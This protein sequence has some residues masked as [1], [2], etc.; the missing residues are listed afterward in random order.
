M[1]KVAILFLVFILIVGFYFSSRIFLPLNI[2]STNESQLIKIRIGSSVKAIADSLEKHGIIKNTDDFLFVVKLFGNTTKLKA[3]AYRLNKG[4]SPYRAMKLIA[5][6]KVSR[7]N[8]V[9]P[10]GLTSYE[11]AS[12]FSK[13]LEIDSTSFINLI[14][15]HHFISS[16]DLNVFSLEGYLFPNT[17]SFYWGITAEE[18][19][20][21]LVK[22][23]HQNFTDSLKNEV[24]EK[25]WSVHQ[26]LT[27]ASIIEGEAMVGSERSLISAVYHNRLKQ[28][29]LLQ[30]DPTIQYI[31]PDGP[32][33]LL[34]R[35]L[36]IDSPYNT[37]RYRGLPPGPVNNP[38]LGSI[39]AAIHPAPVD[40]IYFVAKGDGTHIF[41]R[42]W[43][44]HL[45]AKANFDDYRRTINRQKK[46]KEASRN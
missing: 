35:D 9:I 17:Y 25:G 37:Y 30:A 1:K 23:F 45:R 10:E 28:S 20:K 14:N 33:R 22:E 8:I 15:N 36:E 21:I 2:N 32:R 4:L 27:L 5:A 31:I 34:R 29:M 11:I 46:L 44:E 3:G 24:E 41:S 6:G 40:Y 19:I 12:I 13:K 26:I 38:G 42:T 7:L 39:L 18:A 43:N 16:L